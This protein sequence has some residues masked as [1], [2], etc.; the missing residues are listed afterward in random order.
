MSQDNPKMNFGRKVST[1]TIFIVDTLK[2]KG[3]PFMEDTLES[4]YI[5]LTKSQY[6]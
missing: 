4:H 2:G 6:K 5:K 3:L 1:P